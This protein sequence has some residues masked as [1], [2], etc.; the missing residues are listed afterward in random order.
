MD[1][2]HRRNESGRYDHEKGVP[3]K[4]PDAITRLREFLVPGSGK[5]VVKPQNKQEIDRLKEEEE[6]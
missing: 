4:K 1:E 2:Y 5:G 3:K 6:N